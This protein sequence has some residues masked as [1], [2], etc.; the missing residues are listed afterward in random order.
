MVYIGEFRTIVQ[1]GEIRTD[2]FFNMLKDL[3]INRR[4]F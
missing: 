2:T 1:R 3:R 4:R